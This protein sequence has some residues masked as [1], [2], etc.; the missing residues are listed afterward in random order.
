MKRNNSDLEDL[1]DRENK[2]RTERLANKVASLKTF[3]MDIEHETIE[4]NRLLDNVDD[5][6]DSTFGFLA[7]GRNRVNRLLQSSRSNRKYM[8]YISLAICFILLLI[9]Y[10]ISRSIN[11]PKE[12]L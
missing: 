3:T 6:F 8:C 4:H 11:A 2:V 5:D 12:S 7:N 1:L 9:Y 10:L